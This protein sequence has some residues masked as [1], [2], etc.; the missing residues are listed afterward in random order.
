M[1]LKTRPDRLVRSV[2]PGTGHQF[3]PVKISKIDE[4]WLNRSKIGLNWEPEAK[5][6]FALVWF[7]KLWL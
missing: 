3:G 5:L 4:N 7:L 6:V 1:V 2:Q